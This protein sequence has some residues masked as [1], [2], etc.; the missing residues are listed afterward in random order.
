MEENPVSWSVMSKHAKHDKLSVRSHML[1]AK[2]ELKYPYDLCACYHY[3]RPFQHYYFIHQVTTLVTL[4][5]RLE[6]HG[7]SASPDGLSILRQ[8]M[9]AQFTCLVPHA[10]AVTF[11]QPIRFVIFCSR[12]SSSSL[13]KT[14][15]AQE[16]QV[17]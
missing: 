8:K 2:T 3:C 7:S 1:H 6:P 9:S 10:T 12:H 14:C 11:N 15:L 13:R 17:A 16:N 4:A 5:G